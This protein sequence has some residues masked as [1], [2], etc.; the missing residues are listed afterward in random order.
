MRDIGRAARPHRPRSAEV[1]TLPPGR[2]LPPE[3]E[4]WIVN[5]LVE[6]MPGL[7]MR[8]LFALRRDMISEADC[9][10]VGV[11]RERDRVI[12][13]L[14][15]RW[16]RIPSGLPCLHVMV[17]FVGDEYRN[18]AIFG[19]SWS[20][21]FA[22]LMAEGNP[23]PEVIALKTYNP[24][25]YC[26]MAAFS[27]HPDITMYPGTAGRPVQ[28]EAVAALALEVAQAV[29]PGEPFDPA[30]GVLRGIGRPVD[31]YLERPASY[32]PDANDYFATHAAPGDR[33]LCMLHVPSRSGAHSILEALGIPIP[34]PHK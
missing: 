25:A 32:V 8:E 19:E 12:S 22:Q 7:R 20:A 29:A 3:T 14:S 24:V 30:W 11:D 16:V 4:K 15:S 10:V 9:L 17:Q 33:V 21:H 6:A 31:L 23:F 26:A 1:L 13:I 18:G 27:G 2:E 5:G 34:S 28:N